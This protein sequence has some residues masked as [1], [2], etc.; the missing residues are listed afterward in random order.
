MK[1]PLK[2]LLAVLPAVVGAGVLFLCSRPETMREI[3]AGTE[4]ERLAFLSSCGIAGELLSEQHVTVPGEDGAFADYAALQRVQRLPLASHTGEAAAV[5]TYGIA[6]SSLRAELL[7]AGDRLIG[8]QLYLPEEAR[9]M[10]LGSAL[11]N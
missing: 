7:C 4:D 3:P 10:P 5:Y 2:V 11:T 1:R 6:G 9:A 8:A